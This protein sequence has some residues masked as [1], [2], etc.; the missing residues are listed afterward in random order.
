MLG[1]FWLWLYESERALGGGQWDQLNCSSILGSWELVVALEGGN[2][3]Y[4]RHDE[5]EAVWRHTQNPGER[6]SRDCASGSSQY[7][8][9]LASMLLSGPLCACLAAEACLKS[10]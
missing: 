1:L 5:V 7:R 4:E 8:H 6:S 10:Q 3:V 2:I 9:G